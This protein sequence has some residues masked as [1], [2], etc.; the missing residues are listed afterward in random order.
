METGG[1]GSEFGHTSFE[2]CKPLLY[3]HPHNWESLTRPYSL[4]V[5]NSTF[6]F[7]TT[8]MI[9][10]GLFETDENRK[11]MVSVMLFHGF[12]LLREST[13]A[14]PF[15]LCEMC[16]NLEHDLGFCT[17]IFICGSQDEMRDE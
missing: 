1:K 8:K 7:H 17:I 4:G 11:Q 3:V 15:T 2:V 16:T 9:S 5:R 6:V 14:I 13:W 10:S 12:T